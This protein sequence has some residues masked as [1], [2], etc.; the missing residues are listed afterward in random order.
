MKYLVVLIGATVLDFI[1]AAYI[2]SVAAKFP[3][4]AA[5]WSALIGLTGGALTLSYVGDPWMLL[6]MGVGFW[7]GTYISVRRA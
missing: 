2:T 5:C 3:I 7:L 6:P 4:R 1:W